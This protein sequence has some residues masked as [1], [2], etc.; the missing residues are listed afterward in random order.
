MLSSSRGIVLKMFVID[1]QRNL[2]DV[3]KN[4]EVLTFGFLSIKLFDIQCD[5]FGFE[6]V[7]SAN[8]VGWASDSDLAIQ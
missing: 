6:E 7:D 1:F 5:A 3:L 8:K 2:Y 4:Y